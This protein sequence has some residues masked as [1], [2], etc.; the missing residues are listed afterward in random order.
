MTRPIHPRREY[1]AHLAK[2]LSEFCHDCGAINKEERQKHCVLFVAPD[3]CDVLPREQGGYAGK[4]D[5]AVLEV[6][7]KLRIV[8]ES[9]DL[10]PE[11]FER[12]AAGDVQQ[13]IEDS[14]IKQRIMDFEVSSKWEKE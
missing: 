13:M 2:E 7:V 8:K 4:P 10:T 14:T 6:T 9:Q 12:L 5:F 11:I 3:T 1:R